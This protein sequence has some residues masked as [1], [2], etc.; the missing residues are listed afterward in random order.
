MNQ[1]CRP[2]RVAAPTEAAEQRAVAQYLDARRLLWC[3]VPNGEK[4]N[5]ITGARLR[6]M[7][8]KR[9]C[10]DVIVFTPPPG[11]FGIAGVAIE[12]KRRSATKSSVRPEQVEW[13]HDLE[14]N[15]WRTCV[16]YGADQAIAFLKTYYPER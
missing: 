16:A 8:V 10:P 1:P 6:G 3:H 9:G 13:L 5:P 4:R 14:A 11:K 2:M 12:L 15:G 7:G